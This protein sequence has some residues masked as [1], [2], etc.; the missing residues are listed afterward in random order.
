[1]EFEMCRGEAEMVKR[2]GSGPA[3]CQTRGL[4]K[5]EKNERERAGLFTRGLNRWNKRVSFRGLKASIV[6]DSC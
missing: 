5:T 4:K 1:M 3:D 2:E 6:L